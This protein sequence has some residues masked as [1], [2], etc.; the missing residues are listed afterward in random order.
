MKQKISAPLMGLICLAGGSGAVLSFMGA[1]E[2]FSN[3]N[4]VAGFIC[5]AGAF[6]F[7][8]ALASFC[9]KEWRGDE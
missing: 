3:N 9:M 8:I 5:M 6:F 1:L 2:S 4:A 7:A